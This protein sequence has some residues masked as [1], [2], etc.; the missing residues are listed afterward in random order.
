MFEIACD[1]LIDLC[2]FITP[3][4][5]IILVLNICAYLLWGRGD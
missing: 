1:L 5:S 2:E 3:A 4:V